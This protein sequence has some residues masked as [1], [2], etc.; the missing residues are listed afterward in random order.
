MTAVWARAR[1]ELRRRWRATLALTLLIGFVGAVVLTVVAGARR[2]ATAYDRFRQASRSSHVQVIVSDTD[3]GRLEQVERL[4]QVEALG[5]IAIPVVGPEGTNF[6]PGLGFLAAASPDGS[7][8]TTVD[9]VRVIEGRVP[10]AGRADE[11]G[12]SERVAGDLDLDVGEAI[13]FQSYTPE[14]SPALQS[15]S[16]VTPPA[17]PRATVRVVG[18]LRSPLDLESQADSP[19]AYL[20]P[21]FYRTYRGRIAAFEGLSRVRLRGGQ[22]DLP[23]FD[24]AVRQIYKDDPELVIAPASQEAARVEDAVEVGVVGLLLFAATAGLAGLVA[25]VQSLG[26]HLSHSAPEE[27]VLAGLGMTRPQRLTASTLALVPAIV[28]AALLSAAGAALASPLMPIGVARLAE[29]DPGLSLDADALGVGAIA[30]VVITGAMVVAA[31]WRSTRTTA[32]VGATEASGRSR[33]SAVPRLL[34]AAGLSSAATTG[35]RMAFE[36]GRGSTAVPVRSGLAGAALGVAGLVA[37]LVFGSSLTGLADTPANYGWNWDLS[38][39]ARNADASVE[40]QAAALAADPSVADVATVRTARAEVGGEEILVHGFQSLKGSVVPTVTEGRPPNSPDEVVLGDE[41]LRRLGVGIGDTVEAGGTDGAVRMRIVGRG[42]VP[43]LDTDTVADGVTMTRQ[44]ADRLATDGAYSDLVLN[45]APGID[46]GPAWRRLEEQVGPAIVDK[47]P[48]DVTNLERVEALPRILALFLALLAV[49]A[50]GH[51]LV[52]T[53]RRRRRDLAVLKA[54][55][56]QPHQVSSTVAWQATLL[57]LV[58]LAVGLP[59]GVAIGRWTWSLVAN[60]LGVVNRPVV[61]LAGLAIIVAAGL[62]VAN[63]LAALPA[64]AAGRTQPALVLRTE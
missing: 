18:I 36:P 24:Q 9:Q 61:P 26:R 57:A 23:A 6:A 13:A 55:G 54:L 28:G 17:G 50:V 4:P 16:E 41:T 56:F 2:S 49:L 62:L 27:P 43:F 34:G 45:W 7:F 52:T 33:P 15:V 20:T 47:P 39:P 58:G 8:P 51:T 38:V 64:W 11:V 37:A 25:V 14:Q 44:G 59:L 46:E 21:A 1:A 32:V 29:P 48:A 53:V 19:G 22:A 63:L 5:R 30:L 42:P 60:G 10:D 3:P 31:A 12:I 35:A 40:S